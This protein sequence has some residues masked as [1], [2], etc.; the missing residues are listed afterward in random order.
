MQRD[1]FGQLDHVRDVLVHPP[2]G[3]VTDVD[4]TISEIS[5][6]L[7]AAF[8]PATL[9][10]QLRVLAE[11]LDLVAAISGRSANDVRRMVGID[12][13][14]YVGN[15]GL[16]WWTKG[17]ARLSRGI[18]PYIAIMAHALSEIE[19]QVSFDGVVLENK[20]AT[21][22]VHYRQ[23]ADPDLARAAIL[24]A[25]RSSPAAKTLNITEGKMVIEL[26]PPL[27]VNKGWAL[28]RLVSDHQ[29]RSVIYLGDDITDIDAFTVLRSLRTAGKIDGVAVAVLSGETPVKVVE[30]A[31]ATL[32]GVPEV[33]RFVRWLN[34]EIFGRSA[35]K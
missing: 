12:E 29:L 2:C 21:A 19:S 26:R 5:S 17:R 34:H 32:Q 9:S 27:Q 18:R 20:G 3:I 16:E 1:L 14:V 25:T 35:I 15:H 6:S 24:A 30:Q 31:D 33:E 4:G 13:L 8:V 28:R 23:A 7:D 11:H 10:E 22:T